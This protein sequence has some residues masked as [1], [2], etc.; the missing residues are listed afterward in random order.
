MKK[1]LITIISALALLSCNDNEVLPIIKT[2]V[3]NFHAPETTLMEN[4]DEGI[5]VQIS[6]SVPAQRSETI[7]VKIQG[8]S[9]SLP[10]ETEPSF[11]QS[12]ELTILIPKGSAEVSFKVRPINDNLSLGHKE[13]SFEIFELSDGLIKGANLFFDLTIL[14]N[15]SVGLLKSIET[16]GL[17]YHHR[18]YEY[19]HF[20][21]YKRVLY[22]NHESQP[23]IAQNLYQYNDSGKIIRISGDIGQP[24]QQFLYENGNLKKAERTNF[25]DFLEIDE[26]EIDETGR[27]QALKL[28]R[29]LPSGELGLLGYRAFTYYSN[30]SIQSITDYEFRS[31]IEYEIVKKVTYESYSPANNPLPFYDEIPG[32]ILQ[33]ALP[34]KMVIEE[35]GHV[36]TYQF[37]YTFDNMG[38]V[39]ERK[40][41]GPSGIEITKYLYY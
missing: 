29:L 26:Y 19:T 8:N 15:E 2:P 22:R 6:L 7:K 14:D 31:H 11:N 37:T 23:L 21:S 18:E 33:P 41:A 39:M 30:G 17:G 24:Q 1:F 28:M 32:L 9:T 13:F 38:K 4:D 20:G 3:V 27:P 25:N 40:T 35:D 36:F 12:K 16:K 5:D 10:F 34:L